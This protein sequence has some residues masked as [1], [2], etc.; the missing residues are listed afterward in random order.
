MSFLSCYLDSA[1]F[2]H[3]YTFP[4]PHIFYHSIFSVSAS[5][6]VGQSVQRVG[7]D[8]GTCDTLG[9]CDTLGTD[10]GICDTLGL[11][12]TL[13]IDEGTRLDVGTTVSVRMIE[14]S[15]S[16]FLAFSTK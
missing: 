9:L 3:E 15:F 13:G 6:V 14:S 16:S 4:R 7:T 8:E 2:I 12:D 1:K 10:E 11:C 5:P